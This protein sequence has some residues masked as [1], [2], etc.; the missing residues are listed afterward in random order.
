M[1]TKKHVG[2]DCCPHCGLDKEKHQA[3]ERVVLAAFKM[4]EES[5]VLCTE[6]LMQLVKTLK[7]FTRD[8]DTVFWRR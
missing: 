4:T 5:C 8:K 7:V 3:M 2:G 6:H 1:D